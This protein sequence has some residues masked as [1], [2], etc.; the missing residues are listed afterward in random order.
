M[1]Y[2]E[3][4]TI[5][6]RSEYSGIE[7]KHKVKLWIFACKIL[8]KIKTASQNKT[9]RYSKCVDIFLQP[10][11]Y[12][13]KKKWKSWARY[14]ILLVFLTEL[15]QKNTSTHWLNIKICSLWLN[16]DCRSVVVVF[17]CKIQISYCFKHVILKKNQCFNT[18]CQ[19]G[20]SNTLFLWNI[21]LILM[22]H[23]FG[24]MK[25]TWTII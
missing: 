17:Y 1:S 22:T 16:S 9:L 6:I 21:H 23:E 12:Q 11:R 4:A 10:I 20:I 25:W 13:G 3:N 19:I 14:Q 2:K 7:N 5:Y 8:L 15:I 18:L 24:S